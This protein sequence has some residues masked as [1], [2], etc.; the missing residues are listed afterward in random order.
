[1]IRAS[2]PSCRP[3]GGV[4]LFLAGL[5]LCAAGAA[6]AGPASAPA[7]GAVFEALIEGGAAARTGGRVALNQTAGLGNAQAKRAV[8]AL[9]SA[10]AGD[11]S[12]GAPSSAA[13]MPAV[14]AVTLARAHIAAGA[15]SD[16]RGALALNQSAGV[17]NRQT[18]FLLIAPSSPAHDRLVAGIT[19]VDDAALAVAVGAPSPSSAQA[20]AGARMREATIDRGALTGHRGVLQVNQT[21]GVGNVS[22]NAVLVQLPGRGS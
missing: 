8:L 18:N 4:A 19:S 17:G 20:G 16:G 13:A 3:P 15:L 14:A 1:M 11:L 10:R 5:S 7:S 21:A 22:V 12:I 9:P 2:S 6:A